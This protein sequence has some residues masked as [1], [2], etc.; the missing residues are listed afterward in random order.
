MRDRGKEPRPGRNLTM[1][2]F[3]P[4]ITRAAP[5]LPVQLVSLVDRIKVATKM[6][7]NQYGNFPPPPTMTDSA[8]IPAPT[9]TSLPNGYSYHTA[10]TPLV[11]HYP[12]AGASPY[13]MAAPG[14]AY[15]SYASPA[16][17]R[18]RMDLLGDETRRGEY[19]ASYAQQSS[20]YTPGA[21]VSKVPGAGKSAYFVS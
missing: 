18:A 14:D 16:D 11:T 20:I 17:P 7:Y 8:Y 1:P 21:T 10:S 15:S 9:A 12:M 2:L 13:A 4:P 19:D 5:P 3:L 6:A